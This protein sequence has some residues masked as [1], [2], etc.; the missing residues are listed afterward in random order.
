MQLKINHVSVSFGNKM[1]LDGLSIPVIKAGEVIAL[2]GK[3]GAGK[4]TLLKQMT[5][6]LRLHQ[7]DA[8]LN[9]TK[10]SIHDIGYLPQNHQINAN[11]SVIELLV[12]T[13]NIGNRSLFTKK[14]SVERTVSLLQEMEIAHLANKQCN[15]L[16][17]GES[18]MVGLAQAVINQPNI[19]ILDEPTSAL[20]MSNQ[21]KLL[22]YISWYTR[23]YNACAIMVIHD[24]NLAIQHSN[25]VAAIHEGKLFAYGQP[26]DIITSELIDTLFNIDSQIIHFDD[27]PI[28][29]MSK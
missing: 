15:V 3:N 23:H 4:S 28:V 20:D 27:R 2:I 16:S 5:S 21:L 1:V 11:I 26:K 9:D 19:L 8:T 29:V 6:P 22:N 12:T 14:N 18:Q 24:L 25:K 10:V 7:I 13:L 17:G